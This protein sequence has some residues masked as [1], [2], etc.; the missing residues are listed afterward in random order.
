MGFSRKVRISENLLLDEV[1][2]E[3]VSFKS[4][5]VFIDKH[6]NFGLKIKNV[7]IKL[8]KFN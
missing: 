1:L 8:E 7:G 5:G 3:V 4:L 2:E 6:L